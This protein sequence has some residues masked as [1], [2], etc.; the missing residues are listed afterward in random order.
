MRYHGVQHAVLNDGLGLATRYAHKHQRVRLT[1]NLVEKKM[2]S[3]DIKQCETA[4][5]S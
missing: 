4:A 5:H 1:R 2:I 3:T